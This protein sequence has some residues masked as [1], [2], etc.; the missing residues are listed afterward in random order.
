LPLGLPEKAKTVRVDN[1]ATLATDGP[2]IDTNGAVAGS[3]VLEDDRLGEGL[4]ERPQLSPPLGGE[5]HE[6]AAAVLRIAFSVHPSTGLGLS[7]P[8]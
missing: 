3:F 6:D 5:L 4:I 1:G 2:F 7:S 8:M